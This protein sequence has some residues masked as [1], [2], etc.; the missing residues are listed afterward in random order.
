VEPKGEEMFFDENIYI[1]TFGMNQANLENQETYQ[2]NFSAV[3]PPTQLPQ[4][5]IYS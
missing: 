1:H 3:L 2:V 5:S 4:S